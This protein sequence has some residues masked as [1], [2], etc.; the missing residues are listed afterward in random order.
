MRA[1]LFLFIL[2]LFT[3]PVFAGS[4]AFESAE[5][6]AERQAAERYYYKQT[7][8]GSGFGIS[9]IPTNTNGDVYAPNSQM[10]MK[11]LNPTW[12]QSTYTA[13][14]KSIPRWNSWENSFNNSYTPGVYTPSYTSSP[15]YSSPTYTK[16]GVPRW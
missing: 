5:E 15:L 14:T 10:L 8:H 12:R 3:T 2:F 6:Q 13:P 4:R 16:G 11:N 9:G 1:L 7:V